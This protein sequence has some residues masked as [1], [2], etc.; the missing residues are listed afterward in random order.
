ME[1]DA[2]RRRLE[3]LKISPSSWQAVDYWLSLSQAGA[4]PERA[5]FDPAAASDILRNCGLFDVRPGVSVHCRIASSL[6]KIVMGPDVAGQDWLA[7]TPPRHREQRLARYSAVA[8]GA[9]G[10]GRRKVMRKSNDMLTVEEMMLPFAPNAGDDAC[11]VLLHTDWR[12][13]GEE[14]FGV[15][16]YYGQSLADEFQLVPLD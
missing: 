5:A 14:W 16:R 3:A 7:I 12:P 10:I 9:I 4:I 13:R 1:P 15:D 6:L 11:Q 2:L 8:Q